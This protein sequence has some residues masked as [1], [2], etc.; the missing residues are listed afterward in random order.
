MLLFELRKN[1]KLNPKIADTVDQLKAIRDQY[2]D[3]VDQIFVT[4]TLYNKL[5]INPMSEWD[6]TPIGIYAYPLNYVID[7]NMDVPY[8]GEMPIIQVFKVVGDKHSIWHLDDTEQLLDIKQRLA[9]QYGRARQMEDLSVRDLW[10]FIRLT[11]KTG[12]KMT[13]DFRNAFTRIGIFGIVDN[14]KGV[15][16]DHEPTQAV[17]FNSKMLKVLDVID[18]TNKDRKAAREKLMA[19]MDYENMSKAKAYELACL[20]LPNRSPKLEAKFADNAFYGFQYAFKLR[21][22]FVAG[23]PAIFEDSAMKD[24]YEKMVSKQYHAKYHI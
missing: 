24:Q 6:K 21:G 3:E 9:N 14:G 4:F 11:T 2:R 23:E 17:F 13:V 12:H 22:R 18:N 19:P 5:G 10:N 16:H 15:I 8:A 1:P 20:K 7:H